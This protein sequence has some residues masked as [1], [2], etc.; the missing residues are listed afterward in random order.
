M[1]EWWGAGEAITAT[2]TISRMITHP[3]RLLASSARC[4]HL[5]VHT[6]LITH[7]TVGSRVAGSRADCIDELAVGVISQAHSRCT[8]IACLTA[9]PYLITSP[10]RP[11]NEAMKIARGIRG[12]FTNVARGT[13]RIPFAGRSTGGHNRCAIVEYVDACLRRRRIAIHRARTYFGAE[14]EP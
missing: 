6:N 9:H 11:A 10:T 2:E 4:R 8:R 12:D 3:N 14:P 7:G 5:N 13:I 1:K